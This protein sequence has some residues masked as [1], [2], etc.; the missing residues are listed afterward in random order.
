[1]QRFKKKSPPLS[2]T[3][4]RVNHYKCELANIKR[5][6]VGKQAHAVI[7][8]YFPPKNTSFFQD[9]YQRNLS[10]HCTMINSGDLSAYDYHYNL[11]GGAG[12]P[13]YRYAQHVLFQIAQMFF[14]FFF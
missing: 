2:L 3:Q 5:H 9:E 7:S 1:M 14:K 4:E 8:F 11:Y 12:D 10:R 13:N 6:Q